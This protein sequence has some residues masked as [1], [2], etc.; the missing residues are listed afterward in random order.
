MKKTF[1]SSPELGFHLK[2]KRS[3]HWTNKPIAEYN[4]Q[5]SISYLITQVLFLIGKDR[6]VVSCHALS[7]RN[8][9]NA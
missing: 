5:T 3:I 1:M 6:A 8:A 2:S 7:L 4:F 9:V